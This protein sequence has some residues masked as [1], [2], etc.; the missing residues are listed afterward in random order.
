MGWLFASN[1]RSSVSVRVGQ[2]RSSGEYR[3]TSQALGER[4]RRLV[5]GQFI[6]HQVTRQFP[7][8]IAPRR[9]FRVGVG[10]NQVGEKIPSYKH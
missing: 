6:S 8:T 3:S 5:S 10:L 7:D 9:S 2:T 4:W 1:E